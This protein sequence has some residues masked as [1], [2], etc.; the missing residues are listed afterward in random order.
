MDDGTII[1]LA[2]NEVD[3]GEELHISGA[4]FVKSPNN[5]EDEDENLDLRT[6]RPE[7]VYSGDG[8]MIPLRD[9]TKVDTA[10]RVAGKRKAF[11]LKAFTTKARSGTVLLYYRKLTLVVLKD[12]IKPLMEQILTK[13]EEIRKLKEELKTARGEKEK[14]QK[15]ICTVLT[16]EKATRLLET[17]MGGPPK[18]KRKKD[19]QVETRL[20][21]PLEA[22]LDLKYEQ[23]FKDRAEKIAKN[24]AKIKEKKKQKKNLGK[25]EREVFTKLQ[26]ELYELSRE[27]STSLA[28]EIAALEGNE[29]NIILYFSNKIYELSGYPSADAL[30]DAWK[31]IGKR[32][33]S[34]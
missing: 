2:A 6:E 12:A 8:K 20:S 24:L 13:D 18:K 27:I 31:Q 1:D 9:T 29:N 34:S 5:T 10:E 17:Q 19:G 14:T 30:D 23:R 16:N 15:Q 22:R 4:S 25:S 28:Q 7:F 26:R 33:S 21:E 11:D 32:A 3:V